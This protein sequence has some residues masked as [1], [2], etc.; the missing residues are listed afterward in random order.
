M[1]AGSFRAEPVVPFPSPSKSQKH[2][3]LVRG[4]RRVSV[5]SDEDLDV[6]KIWER[7]PHKTEQA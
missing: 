2:W 4:D 6:I 1:E 5:V 3:S 7:A